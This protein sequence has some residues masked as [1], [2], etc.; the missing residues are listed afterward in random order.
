MRYSP[1]VKMQSVSFTTAV[2]GNATIN[3]SPSYGELVRISYINDN[4]TDTS[5]TLGLR[6]QDNNLLSSFVLGAVDSTFIPTTLTVLGLV[7]FHSIS[8]N[9]SATIT[10]YDRSTTGLLRFYFA[11]GDANAQQNGGSHP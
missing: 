1:G 11:T 7:N 9:F 4:N 8:G 5:W 3:L 2:T 10:G 6:D